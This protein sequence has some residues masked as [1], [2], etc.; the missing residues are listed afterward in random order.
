MPNVVHVPGFMTSQISESRKAV[1]TIG[2]SIES[3][4][5]TEKV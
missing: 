4:G 3:M 2:D 5:I 1:T